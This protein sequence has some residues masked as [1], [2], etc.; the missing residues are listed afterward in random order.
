MLFSPT[1]VSSSTA[2][3]A[4]M[5]IIGMFFQASIELPRIGSDCCDGS[6]F[7]SLMSRFWC[8]G[9]PLDLFEAT[10]FSIQAAKG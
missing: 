4:M 5:A 6:L 1:F 9:I 2:R 10:V 7:L 8:D 3:K